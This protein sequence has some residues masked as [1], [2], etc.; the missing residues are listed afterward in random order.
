[1]N[2]L[3]VAEEAER[4][5]EK[6]K[7]PW[8]HTIRPVT[9]Q[10]VEG[11]W[12]AVERLNDPKTAA[13][14]T[15]ASSIKFVE[16]VQEHMRQELETTACLPN[17]PDPGRVQ[18]HSECLGMIADHMGQFKDVFSTMKKM[19]DRA[20]EHYER[21]VAQTPRIRSE[22]ATKRAE[23]E[24]RVA[25]ALTRFHFQEQDLKEKLAQRT[26]AAAATEER[27]LNL[28]DKLEELKEKEKM[29]QERAKTFYHTQEEL[30]TWENEK[31]EE[32]QERKNNAKEKGTFI[33]DCK[34]SI[35]VAKKGLADTL[36]EMGELKAQI[37]VER[38]F[39]DHAEI[40]DAKQRE[41]KLLKENRKLRAEVFSLTNKMESV[42]EKQTEWESTKH[43]MKA[44]VDRTPRPDWHSVGE[45]VKQG[46]HTTTKGGVDDLIA[47]YNKLRVKKADLMTRIRDENTDESVDAEEEA[48]AADQSADYFIGLGFKTSVPAC[49]RFRGKVPN[50]RLTKRDTVCAIRKMWVSKQKHDKGKKS[51]IPMNKF[52]NMY[53]KDT[54]PVHKI[55]IEHAYNL[56][57]SVYA[58]QANPE[59]EMFRRVLLGEWQEEVYKDQMRMLDQLDAMICNLDRNDTGLI[60]KTR[61][62][63]ALRAF[64]HTKSESDFQVIASALE[65]DSPGPD[66]QYAKI[67][68]ALHDELGPNAN[69]FFL[70]AVR[71]QYL[72]E[73]DIAITLVEEQLD[74]LMLREGEKPPLTSLISAFRKADP[75]MS[76]RIARQFIVKVVDQKELPDN[77]KI[78]LERF[79][80]VV[81]TR[82]IHRFS[83][84]SQTAF[85]QGA[86]SPKS[87]KKKNS[88][89]NSNI[90]DFVFSPF[91]LSGGPLK[92]DAQLRA[93]HALEHAETEHRVEDV[94]AAVSLAS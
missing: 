91:R 79:K 2:R 76:T 53:F 71:D 77:H 67:F 82:P 63:A 17:G 65:A 34:E 52:V 68:G 86:L 35:K 43:K 11:L 9:P 69:S 61:F 60:P 44:A 32:V 20:V 56:I 1:L 5:F 41:K 64:Y 37:C 46:F 72:E 23:H 22:L 47:L 29:M 49:L 24:Q 70:E 25:E 13:E 75:D 59:C 87:P 54:Y 26:E 28:Y 55:A 48:A 6:H 40:L 10:S 90:L 88:H 51:L 39:V 83:P 66:A 78:D 4:S 45:M 31:R 18:I 16:M 62:L 30:L 73:R 42:L 84:V 81:R 89:V 36:V 80:A 14:A 12:D 94:A 27:I 7:S 92:Y 38:K 50:R 33:E 19:Y 58:H 15:N 21:E 85:P 93:D 57:D 8:K 74:A 3:V